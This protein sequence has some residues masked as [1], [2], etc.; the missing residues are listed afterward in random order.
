MIA[1]GGGLLGL[2]ILVITL[3]QGGGGG[4]GLQ[5]GGARTG[6]NNGDLAQQCQTG[7]DANQR[8]DCRIV[9]VVDSVQAFWQNRVPTYRRAQTVFFTQATSTGC[10]SATSDVGPFYCPNDATVYIDLGFYDELRERFGANGGPFAEAYV[11][12]HEYGH[13]IQDLRGVFARSQD[14]STGPDSS[15]VRIELMAD[16]LA[17]VWARGAKDTGFIESLSDDDIRDGLNAAAAIGD[18]RIQQSA[19]GR[20]DKET[21][22]HGSSE[23]RQR[24]LLAGYRANNGDAACDTFSVSH[25]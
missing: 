22:T 5:I 18:D 20:V 10:G 4:G 17:G 25:V 13:H 1:G 24:W 8:E 9:A 21:W 12:A 23:Q 2:V 14:G 15:S 19:Q 3:L 7:A 11:I 16:C 6:G